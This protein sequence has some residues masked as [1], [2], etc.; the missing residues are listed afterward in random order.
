MVVLFSLATAAA[1]GVAVGPYKGKGT[2][3]PAL[4]RELFDRF[5]A[6]DVFLGDCYFCSYFLLAL[7]LA[8]QVDVVVRQRIRGTLRSV[9]KWTTFAGRARRWCAGKSGSTGWLTT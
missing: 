8:Q 3:E 9:C 4:L 1:Y 5:E 2:G 6:G 7:F